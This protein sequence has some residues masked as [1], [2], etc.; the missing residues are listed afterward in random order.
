MDAKGRWPKSIWEVILQPRQFSSFN[1][2]DPN[3]TLWPHASNGGDWKAW[4]DILSEV[5]T[6][7]GGDS[8]N[9]ANHYESEPEDAR[10]AWAD[11]TKL[12]TTIGPFRFYRL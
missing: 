11:S 5:F 3:A 6:P 9:G 7:I 8:T 12:T 2:G 4:Q 1:A 10:P